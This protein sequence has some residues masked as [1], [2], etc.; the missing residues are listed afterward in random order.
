MSIAP[1]RVPLSRALHSNRSLA[2]ARYFQL[3]TVCP[4]GYPGNRTVVFRGFFENALKIITDARSQKVVQINHN[5]GAEI[6]WYFPKTREQFRLKG[7]LILV[8]EDY[9]ELTLKNER[10]TTW[11]G[12]SDAA[13]TQFVWSNPGEPRVDGDPAFSQPLPDPKQPLPNFCL[14]LLEPIQV[15][16]L[17]LH[18][19]PQNRWRYTQQC[20]RQWIKQA[21]N[22]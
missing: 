18:G 16:H 20:D 4:D 11:Q 17:E 5:A 10:Q 8:G 9:P 15:D 7:Q 6:C 19:D 14:L 1:W 22:P 21:I 2:Y 13:R 3:A 12:L